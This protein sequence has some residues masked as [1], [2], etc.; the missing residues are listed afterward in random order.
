MGADRRNLDTALA[1]DF[2]GNGGYELLLPN[3]TFTDWGAVRRTERGAEIS[4]S[5]DVGEVMATN[6][7]AVILQDGGIVVGGGYDQTLRL[8]RP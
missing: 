2:D 8:W 1:G 5:L 4:W 3:P 7:A 6:L